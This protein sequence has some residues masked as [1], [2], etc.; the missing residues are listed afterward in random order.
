MLAE[1]VVGVIPG[2]RIKTGLFS[3]KVYTFVFT[4]R[5]LIL[6][7]MTDDVYKHAVAAARSGAAASGAGFFGKWAAQMKAGFSFGQQYLG[8]DPG[9]IL[10]ETPGNSALA[11]GNIRQLRIER[12]E[13]SG[14]SDN[15]VEQ[16]YLRI[17]LET[18]AEKR[19]F[20][21]QFER[22]GLDEARAIADRLL[23]VA[24]R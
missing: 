15:D 4:D 18:A 22:P 9:A 16:P 2:A 10:A 14:G 24:V 3:S 19:T 12:K 1:Q 20:E 6:A 11:A 23:G 17:T 13:R 7:E 8:M 5:R 21:T